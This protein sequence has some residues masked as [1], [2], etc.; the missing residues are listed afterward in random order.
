MAEIKTPS[1]IIQEV[2]PYYK[3]KGKPSREWKIGYDSSSESLEPVYF[4]ILD[5][6]NPMFGEKVEKLTDNFAASPG[7]ATFSDFSQK[8]QI[9]Q[10]MAAKIG[11]DVNTVI[12]SI[13]NLIYDLKEFELRLEHYKKA[14][15]GKTEDEREAGMIALKQIWMDQVDLKKG[16]GSINM[17]AQ[18]LSFV[19][20]RDAFIVSNSIESAEKLDLN[21]RVKRILRSRL[22]EFFE[23]KERSYKE[24]KKRYEVE[25]TYLKSQVASLNMYSKW[26]KPYLIAA[27]KLSMNQYSSNKPELVNAFNTMLMQLTLFAKK[28]FNGKEN[29]GILDKVVNHGLPKGFDKIN[30]KRHYYSCLLIDFTFRGIPSKLPQGGFTYGGKVDFSIKAYSLNDDELK[31]FYKKLENNDLE[32]SLKL[33]ENMTDETIAQLKEDLEKYLEE[34]SGKKPEPQPEEKEESDINPFSALIMPLFKGDWFKFGKSKENPEAKEKA[35]K[36]YMA[37]LEKEGVSKD[38][39]YEEILRKESEKEAVGN[40]FTVYDIYKKS[41]GMASVPIM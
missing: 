13:Q 15:E 23:W 24:L 38:N 32:A 19:T 18:D 5:F 21:D 20:L 28:D 7:G 9:M 4:W 12:K 36:A 29:A 27:Q 41:H 3:K 35:N 2:S 40:S 31:L 22:E 37:K 34:E 6:I 10:Q 1:E 30:F 39:F 16:R 14:T 17:M 11:G 8:A 33:V 25:K 26:A